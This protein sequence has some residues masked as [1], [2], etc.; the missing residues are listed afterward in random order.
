MRIST[1][2][3]RQA[4]A[5]PGRYRT[6]LR[7]SAAGLACILAVV[8]C[9]GDEYPKSLAVD[10]ASQVV[11]GVAIYVGVVPSEIIQGHPPEHVERDMHGGPSPGTRRYHVVLAL[12]DS[13]SGAR[14]SDAEVKVGLSEVALPGPTKNLEPMQVAGTVT[15]GNYFDFPVDGQY[16]IRVQIRRARIPGDIN[17]VFSHLHIS[18]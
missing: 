6:T 14:I 4:V 2:S 12:F 15:Y 8:S 3:D 7:S 10:S 16:R 13:K 18:P 1:S 17:A 9:T 5:R 11:D